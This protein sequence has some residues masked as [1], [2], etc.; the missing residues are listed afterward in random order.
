MWHGIYS[1]DEQSEVLL[2]QMPDCIEKNKKAYQQGCDDIQGPVGQH[3]EDIRHGA[4]RSVI[5]ED[6]GEDGGEDKMMFIFGFVCGCFFG[7]V[8]AACAMVSREAEEREER[9]AD[10]DRDA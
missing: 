1:G 3:E 6:S 8:L 2:K 10:R 4:R 7:L 9:N 5:R